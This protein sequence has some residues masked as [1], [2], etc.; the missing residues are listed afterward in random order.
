MVDRILIPTDGSEDSYDAAR[1]AIE[2][3]EPFGAEIHVV[4]VVRMMPTRDRL[5]YDPRDEAIEAIED[6]TELIESTK[7]PLVSE[8][9]EG[10]PPQEIVEYAR[11]NH[12]DMIVMGTHGRTGID[13]VLIGSVA[14]RT[15]R[16]SPVPVLTVPPGERH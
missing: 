3:A 14:E 10:F 9:L 2:L 5:R 7:L 8:V 4:S 13:R 1:T 16:T 6:I 15:V 11:N 12:I